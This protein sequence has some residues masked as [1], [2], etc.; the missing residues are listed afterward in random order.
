MKIVQLT[1]HTFRH[2]VAEDLRLAILSGEY[3]AGGQLAE[4]ELAAR[5]GISRGPLREAL[6][7]LVEEG[8]LISVPYKGTYVA[9]LSAEDVREIQSFRVAIETF[10]F[11]L[12]WGRRDEAFRAE[13]QNR[14][15]RL[16]NVVLAGDDAASISAELDLHG[17]VYETA[18]HRLLLESWS[19]LKRKL[20][21]YWATHHRAHERCGPALD[22]HDTYVA[23]ALGDDLAAM[24]A[25][26]REHM[27]R[28]LARTEAFL[29]G[30]QES[31]GEKPQTQPKEQR[32]S[33]R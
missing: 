33:S 12:I 31:P 22:G 4:A 16:K 18:G 32:K 21:L 14:H 7:Q 15:T 23:I 11:Q 5:F 10:A 9:E 13:L 2:H 25:E 29:A 26:I 28:G 17:L 3:P 19:G 24:E 8:L 27:Q 6:R 20:Q 1:R 30:R